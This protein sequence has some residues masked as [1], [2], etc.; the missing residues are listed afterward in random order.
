MYA[1]DA[2]EPLVAPPSWGMLLLLPASSLRHPGS[3]RRAEPP[4]ASR[5]TPT[6]RINQRFPSS[7]SAEKIRL[8]RYLAR[9]GVA[10]RRRADEMIAGGSVRINGRTVR[11]LGTL[12]AAGDRVEFGGVPVE[13]PGAPTYL[14]LNKPLGVVTTMRDP[15]GAPQRCRLPGRSSAVCSPSAGSTM[16]Q[17]D[18]CCLPMTANWLTGCFTQLG[19]EQ[20]VSGRDR[21]ARFLRTTCGGLLAGL[22][23]NDGRAARTGVRV[24]AV[25]R[26]RSLVNVTIHEGR[27]RQVRRMFETLNHPVLG[28]DANSIRAAQARSAAAGP[29]A[30][31]DRKRD[32]GTAAR[33]AGRRTNRLVPPRL[34]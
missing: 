18:Y 22:V 27:N 9:A 29:R 13:L 2:S 17:P 11:E 34:R 7:N 10:S 5:K 19:R 28:I 24:L 3:A 30:G 32:R 20:D 14:I 8:N 31:A 25:R 26:D 6:F 21:G 23:M 12:V 4:A 16:I 1:H 33:I 15:H